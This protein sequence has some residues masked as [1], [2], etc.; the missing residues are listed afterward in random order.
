[1]ISAGIQISMPPTSM[2]LRLYFIVIIFVVMIMNGCTASSGRSFLPSIPGYAEKDK[3]QFILEDYLLEISGICY[4]PDGRVAAHNDEKGVLFIV[5]FGNGEHETIQFSGKG[6]YEDV[7]QYRDAYYILESNGDLHKV[8]AAPPY[9]ADKFKFEDVK[10]IEFEALYVDS[11]ADRLVMLTKNHRSAFRGIL[12]YG[13]DLKTQQFIPEPLY[14]IPMADILSKMQDNAAE[15]KASGAAVHPVENKV[16]VIASLG[17][18]MLVCSLQGKVEQV[19]KLNPAH[20]PQPEGIT[21]APNGD[22]YISNEGL[23]GKA[24]ILMFP[25]VRNGS[26]K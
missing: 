15:C 16:Y 2:H 25:F 5:N 18:A 26:G 9:T 22:M 21:F 19:F 11:V 13:F 17:K 6:D 14:R 24:T 12:A 7:T 1:L 3:E 10:K 23:Q 8:G 20:F 4:L